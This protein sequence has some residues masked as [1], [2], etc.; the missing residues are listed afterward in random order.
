ML[1]FSYQILYYILFFFP[2]FISL[3]LLIVTFHVY[4]CRFIHSCTH[5]HTRTYAH[6]HRSFRLDFLYKR[7]NIGTSKYLLSFCPIHFH[8]WVKFTCIYV[9]FLY[10]F[11]CWWASMLAID[12][13]VWIFTDS[14]N[15]WKF[16]T[17]T[18]G[19]NPTV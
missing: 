2:H 1:L 19:L 18:S 3:P 12:W 14:M 13:L 9:H 16:I 7:S 5:T 8:G 6:T 4:T 11:I 15:E 10:N 17:N